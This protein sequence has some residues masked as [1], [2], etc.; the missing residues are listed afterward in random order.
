MM[1]VHGRANSLNWSLLIA[2][3]NIGREI[4]MMIVVQ[5]NICFA[6]KMRGRRR[7]HPGHDDRESNGKSKKQK[8]HDHHLTNK[9]KNGKIICAPPQ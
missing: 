5:S 9:C 2:V 7:V 1:M 8:A 4:E 6:F 3:A